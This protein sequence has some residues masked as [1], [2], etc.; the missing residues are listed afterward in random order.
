[1][2]HETVESE[3]IYFPLFTLQ[4]C[5]DG[6]A[7]DEEDGRG[8]GRGKTNWVVAHCCSGGGGGG[9]R[10]WLQTVALRWFFLFSLLFFRSLIFLFFVFLSLSFFLCFL[11]FSFLFL[12]VCLC[13]LSFCSSYRFLSPL[14]SSLSLLSLSNNVVSVFHSSLYSFSLFF[15]ASLSSLSPSIYKGKTRKRGL[16]PLSSHGIGVGWS[17]SYWAAAHMAFP[18]YFFV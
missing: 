3:L 17:D 18:L 10:M 1:M 8:E 9:G 4:N 12:P 16:L 15:P 11:S 7:A 6:K 5:R 2:Q 13:F 14:F